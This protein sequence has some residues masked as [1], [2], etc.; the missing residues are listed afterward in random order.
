VLSGGKVVV[1]TI[2]FNNPDKLGAYAD[3]DSVF[4]TLAFTGD[5]VSSDLTYK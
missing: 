5:E 2:N 1:L 3:R 4:L